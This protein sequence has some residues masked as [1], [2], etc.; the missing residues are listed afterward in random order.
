MFPDYK[1]C[2]SYIAKTYI[3]KNFINVMFNKCKSKVV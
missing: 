1:K 3:K 2:E